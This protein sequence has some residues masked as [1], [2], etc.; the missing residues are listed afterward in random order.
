[1]VQAELMNHMR[2]FTSEM[3]THLQDELQV[4]PPPCPPPVP[5]AASSPKSFQCAKERDPQHYRHIQNLCERESN[6]PTYGG[7]AEPAH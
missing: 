3:K 4:S 1:V 7:A 2:V 6:L 5:L